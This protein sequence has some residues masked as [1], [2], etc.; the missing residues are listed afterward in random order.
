MGR[1]VLTNDGRLLYNGRNK[2][3]IWGNSNYDHGQ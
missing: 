2:Y 1:V 3:Y